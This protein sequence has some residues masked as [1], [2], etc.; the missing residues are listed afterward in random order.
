MPLKIACSGSNAIGNKQWW[1][2]VASKR[3]NCRNVVFGRQHKL[4]FELSRR[5]HWIVQ[6]RTGCFLLYL[7]PDIVYVPCTKAKKGELYIRQPDWSLWI[8]ETIKAFE[9]DS[10]CYC[11][12]LAKDKKKVQTKEYSVTYETN[13]GGNFSKMHK[14][15]TC[16]T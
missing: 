16:K 11:D 4:N 2:I 1:T 15:P 6:M 9:R 13:N 5:Q 12:I 14:V 8:R 7:K 3:E 10:C